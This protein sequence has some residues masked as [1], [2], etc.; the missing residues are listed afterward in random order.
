VAGIPW[1]AI[2]HVSCAAAS[3]QSSMGC[4]LTPSCR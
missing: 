1:E 2:A 4:V 3:A